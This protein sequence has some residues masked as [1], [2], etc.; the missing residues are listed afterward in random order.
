[1]SISERNV[2]VIWH[3]FQLKTVLSAMGLNGFGLI[4]S[5]IAAILKALQG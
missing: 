5:S 4:F 3:K 1:M 2:A